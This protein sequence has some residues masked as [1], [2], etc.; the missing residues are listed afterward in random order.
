[1]SSSIILG[2]FPSNTGVGYAVFESV[3]DIIDSG[4]LVTS[5]HDPKKMLSRVVDTLEYYSPKLV[6]LRVPRTNSK[7]SKRT[8]ELIRQIETEAEQLGLQVEYISRRQIKDVFKNI[9]VNKYE[10]AKEIREHLKLQ[11][12]RLP[13]PRKIGMKEDCTMPRYDAMALVLTFYF[14]NES[15]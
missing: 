15:S 11:W 7:T 4:V 9:G 1:M 14:L 12:Y 10:I 13:K 5:L 6:V 2:L 3:A 8:I